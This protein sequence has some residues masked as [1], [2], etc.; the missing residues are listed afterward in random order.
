M[1]GPFSTSIDSPAEHADHA[2]P[3]VDTA[4]QKFPLLSSVFRGGGGGG[5]G[6][7]G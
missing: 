4:D 3:R 6:G 2:S 7:G 1:E 5:G